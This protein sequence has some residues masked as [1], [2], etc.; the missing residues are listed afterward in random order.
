VLAYHLRN[1][2]PDAV[3]NGKLRMAHSY[4]DLGAALHTLLEGA[5]HEFLGDWRCPSGPLAMRVVRRPVAWL[6]V[7]MAGSAVSRAA[8]RRSRKDRRN[9]VINSREV[10]P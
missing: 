3:D 8:L 6:R 9:S 1:V 2:M 5:G 10:S 4:L 7:A